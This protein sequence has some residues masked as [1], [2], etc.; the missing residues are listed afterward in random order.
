MPSNQILSKDN[1]IFK[2]VKEIPFPEVQRAFHGDEPKQNKIYCPFHQ[3]QESSFHIYDDGYKCYGCGDKGDSIDFVAK[4]HSMKPLEAAQEI[5]SAFNLHISI[6][7][8]GGAIL[9]LEELAREKRIPIDKLREYGVKEN[10][11]HIHMQC[12]GLGKDPSP[13]DRIRKK[14]NSGK[15]HWIWDPEDKKAEKVPYGV[16]RIEEMSSCGY[17]VLVEGETDCWTLWNYDIPAFGI[18]GASMAKSVLNKYDY[19]QPFSKVYVWDEQDTGG[20]TFIP[21]VVEQLQRL[22]YQGDV[23]VIKSTE[24]KDPNELHIKYGDSFIDKWNKILNNAEKADLDMLSQAEAIEQEGSQETQKLT[25]AQLLINLG[26]SAELFHAPDETCYATFQVGDHYETWRLRDKN[27]KM[28]LNQR[29]YEIEGKPPGSQA[30]QDALGVLEAEAYYKYKKQEVYTRV[31]ELRGKVY[32]DLCNDGWDVIE[33]DPQGWRI[34][35]DSPVKFRRAKGMQAL[36]M[37]K[38]GGNIEELRRF[39]NVA[40]DHDRDWILLLSWLVG[41][42]RARGPYPVMVL[43]GEQGSAKSTTAKVLKFLTDP[44]I[45][46]LKSVPKDERDHFITANNS[47]ILSFDNLS[48]MAPWL[49]DALCRTAT[50]GG[51]ATRTLYT[52]SEETIFECQRPIIMNGIDEVIGKQDLMNRS[53][54]LHLPVIQEEGRQDEESFWDA[55]EQARPKIFGAIL[56]CISAALRNVDSV[57]LDK[58]PRMA[59]FA[60]WVVAAEEA[61]PWESGEFIKAYSLNQEEASKSALETDVVASAIKE[62]LVA[63]RTWKGTAT[64]WLEELESGGYVRERAANTRAWPQTA[65]AMGKKIKRIAPLLRDSGIFVEHDR[66]GNKRVIEMEVVD[67][68]LLDE[69]GAV[70]EEN[71]E[72]TF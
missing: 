51:Y 52:D 47:W 39:V 59:D 49:S 50:G 61:L 32:I 35:K 56:D 64:E 37:P 58:L 12:F 2:K 38:G 11:A 18:P 19:I 68:K 48:G 63:R 15:H 42:F 6:N 43:Q 55:F 67:S 72:N 25:Q 33:V 66:T 4:L 8:R 30:V 45:T 20:K 9:T 54:I 10:G 40:Q 36:P 44:S 27:F 13:R 46:A 65:K 14:D 60:K 70:N 62:M 7:N 26:Q 5:A 29:F 22:E 69:F 24:V 23:Y 31:G 17:I 34:L 41:A 3:E 53:I 28:W 57:R 1:D 21:K 16:W 71:E